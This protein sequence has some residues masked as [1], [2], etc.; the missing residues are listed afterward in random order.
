MAQKLDKELEDRLLGLLGKF[1][2]NPS[3]SS[4]DKQELDDIIKHLGAKKTMEDIR[5]EYRDNLAQDLAEIQREAKIKRAQE[6]LNTCEIN[7][8]WKFQNIEPD[9]QEYEESVRQGFA[10]ISAFPKYEQK[11]FLFRNNV[12]YQYRAGSLCYIYGEFGVGKSMLAGAMARFL[13]ENFLREVI[14]TQWH[15][16]SIRL[17]ALADNIQ[18]YNKYLDRILN[19]DL[20]VIDEVCVDKI[21]LTEAQRRDLGEILRSRK[22]LGK[23]TIVISNVSP[24]D[25]PKMVGDFCNESIRNYEFVVVIHLVGKNHRATLGVNTTRIDTK[26]YVES[27][28]F[29]GNLNMAVSNQAPINQELNNTAYQPPVPQGGYATNETSMRGGS[30]RRGQGTENSDYDPCFENTWS[31]RE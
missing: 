2:G 1:L 29:N 16:I 12:N 13:I 30:R 31:S 26:Y 17:N 19:V 3:T 5:K 24:L 10:W 8:H 11:F 27:E 20:L 14:F 7:A 22:N 25:L 18:E 28:K 15:T 23:S 6:L 9:S 21:P 4:I